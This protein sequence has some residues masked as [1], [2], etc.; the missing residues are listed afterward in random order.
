MFYVGCMFFIILTKGLNIKAGPFGIKS[1]L[2]SRT[3]IR[4]CCSQ[5]SLPVHISMKT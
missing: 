5:D 1:T 4:Q 3:F 2:M